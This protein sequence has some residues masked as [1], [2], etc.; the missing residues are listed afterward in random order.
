MQM[1]N[2]FSKLATQEQANARN[3]EFSLG[4]ASMDKQYELQ[5]QF[6]NQQFSRDIA[7]MAATGEQ[8]RKNYAAQGVQNRLQAVTEGEQDRL[9]YAAQGDQNRKTMSHAD[10]IE[11][12]KE[13]RHRDYATQQSRNF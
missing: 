3:H 5:N 11:A 1:G 6:A 7:G 9:G 10:R 13:K 4:M 8:E 12:G 2:Y